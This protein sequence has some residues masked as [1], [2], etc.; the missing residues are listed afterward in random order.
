MGRF[1]PPS[2]RIPPLSLT[3][4]H[5]GV[6]VSWQPRPLP[7]RITVNRTWPLLLFLLL[8][9]STT[10]HHLDRWRVKARV[11][12][13]VFL[14]LYRVKGLGDIEIEDQIPTVRGHRARNEHKWMSRQQAVAK[15][16]LTGARKP[17][18]Q[19]ICVRHD[20]RQNDVNGC[21]LCDQNRSQY[22]RNHVEG[23]EPLVD[24]NFQNCGGRINRTVDDPSVTRIPAAPI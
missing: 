6:A 9:S 5:I 20:V 16:L 11:Q 13:K 23:F 24:S 17:R 2:H 14:R 12:S 3:V 21:G 15:R 4:S 19:P 8:Q 10:R 7:P 22:V 18:S 1:S